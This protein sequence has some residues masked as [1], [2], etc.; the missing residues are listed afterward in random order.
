MMFSHSWRCSHAFLTSMSFN[1]ARVPMVRWSFAGFWKML[2]ST[3]WSYIVDYTDK[4]IL[5]IVLVAWC[6]CVMMCLVG[7]NSLKG[8]LLQYLWTLLQHFF[9]KFQESF[10]SVGMIQRE[11]QEV[12]KRLLFPETIKQ[13]LDSSER[14]GH[15]GFAETCDNCQT[16]RGKN[17][18][19]L[20]GHIQ[21]SSL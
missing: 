9:L 18:A 3:P 8:K 5:K 1:R 17:S 19:D 11:W 13:N 16:K 2:S 12:R 6:L 10:L 20:D 15:C 4:S 7:K 21:Q 14:R